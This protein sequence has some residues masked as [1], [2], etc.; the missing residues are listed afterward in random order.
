MT[1]TVETTCPSGGLGS[2]RIRDAK[3]KQILQIKATRTRSFTPAYLAK[4]L[5][6]WAK[7]HYFAGN[8]SV[9]NDEFL[10]PEKSI[11]ALIAIAGIPYRRRCLL[12]PRAARQ[13]RFPVRRPA[14]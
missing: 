13:G 14:I 11:A 7:Y 12:P 8:N 2:R 4:N 10:F 1:I 5:Y 6:F 9:N 3:R